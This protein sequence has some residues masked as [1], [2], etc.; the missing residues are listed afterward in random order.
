[1]DEHGRPDRQRR[2]ED[3]VRRAGVEEG[4]GAPVQTGSASVDPGQSGDPT[5]SPGSSSRQPRLPFPEAV[6][7]AKHQLVDDAYG[8]LSNGFPVR[9][10]ERRLAARRG[11]G[12]GGK[13]TAGEC[14]DGAAGANGPEARSGPALHLQLDAARATSHA[15]HHVIEPD[16]VLEPKAGGEPPD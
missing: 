15:R 16:G 7:E 12:C 1:G 2:P 3:V 9:A 13:K 6:S 8:E 5:G 14:D 10:G 11:P 4:D